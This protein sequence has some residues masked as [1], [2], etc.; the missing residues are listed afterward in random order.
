MCFNEQWLAGREGVCVPAYVCV[1]A[2]VSVSL[3][4]AGC[5]A[6][7][8]KDVEW[9][10]V[11]HSITELPVASV[12]RAQTVGGGGR[13]AQQQQSA[14]VTSALNSSV[15]RHRFGIQLSLQ[16]IASNI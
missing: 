5:Q 14:I 1:R 7:D 6:M 8:T 9:L 4:L 15:P 3:S 13:G 2:C 10:G 16:I 12:R 11:W